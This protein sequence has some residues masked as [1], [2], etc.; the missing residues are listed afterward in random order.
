MRLVVLLIFMVLTLIK[1]QDQQKIPPL[2]QSFSVMVESNFLDPYNTTVYTF[3]YY[4][5]A[6]ER[7]RIEE[8]SQTG[9]EVT[10]VLPRQK[11]SYRLV[12][13]TT[14]CTTYNDVLNIDMIAGEFFVFTKDLTYT[15][16]GTSNARGIATDMWN[17]TYEG[18]DPTVQFMVR[19]GL[20]PPNTDLHSTFNMSYQFSVAN[21]NMKAGSNPEFRVPVK[22]TMEG[23]STF[24]N[25]TTIPLS[26]Q[27]NFM[28]FF[29]G[30]L[31]DT[32][33]AQPYACMSKGPVYTK[34][35]AFTAG[36]IAGVVV[37]GI[38]IIAAVVGRVLYLRRNPIN[39]GHRLADDAV[40]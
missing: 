29:Y 36:G 16:V 23:N 8:H 17:A 2:P 9:S 34:S 31:S 5:N 12:V 4:D 21:W 22:A 18:K 11:K 24:K 39:R 19:I 26:R 6:N 7:Y 38:I 28:D 1:A 27:Y 40:I 35:E 32:L 33:F 20:I 30:N 15:Y 13:G 3:G 25:G 10:I 37:A 14:N